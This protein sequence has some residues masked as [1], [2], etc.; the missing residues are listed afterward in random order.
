MSIEWEEVERTITEKIDKDVIC[1]EC[2]EVVHIF[3]PEDPT[4]ITQKFYTTATSRDSVGRIENKDYCDRCLVGQ[5]EEFIKKQLNGASITMNRVLGYLEEQEPEEQEPEE[6]EPE[7]QES[8]EQE[9]EEQGPEEQGPEEQDL[10]E[11]E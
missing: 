4:K 8:E 10:E 2:G 6:Q 5:S 3:N 11:Q 9:P 7:E 1:D